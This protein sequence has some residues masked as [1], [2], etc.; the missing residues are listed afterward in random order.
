[1]FLP[2]QVAVPWSEYLPTQQWAA[3]SRLKSKC[4]LRCYKYNQKKVAGCSCM[5]RVLLGRGQPRTDVFIGR[6]GEL[7]QVFRVGVGAE[8]LVTATA[9]VYFRVKNL[10]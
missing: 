5:H 3:E 1:M 2:L 10:Y 4:S 7:G 8:E 6:A 9:R